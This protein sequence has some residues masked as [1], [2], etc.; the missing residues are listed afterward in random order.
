MNCDQFTANLGLYLDGESS[1]AD[2]AA[3]ESHVAECPDCQ[4]AVEAARRDD[5]E[6]RRAF[7]ERRSAS[8]NLAERVIELVRREPF[9]IVLPPSARHHWM[10]PGIAQLLLAAAAGFFLAV[11]I[12][13]P[14]QN[15]REAPVRV[16]GQPVAQVALATGPVEI[17]P[18]NQATWDACEPQMPLAAGTCVRT[19]PN[20][21]CEL[22]TSDGNSVCLAGETEVRLA[23]S[24][25]VEVS[26]GRLYSCNSAGSKPLEIKSPHGT[27]VAPPATLL[28]FTC[29]PVQPASHAY[30][31]VVEGE[32]TVP[33]AKEAIKAGKKVKLV[34]G[35]IADG[36]A[37][38]PWLDTAWINSLLAIQSPDQ[39]QL[40]QRVNHL[41]AQV[42]ATKLSH[43]YEDEL[44]RLGDAGTPPLVQYLKSTYD[45]PDQPQR[46]TAA[47]IIAEVGQ[48]QRIPDLIELLADSNPRV[49][50]HAAKGL[51]RLTG[52]DQ[53]ITAEQWE[54][55]PWASCEPAHVKWQKWWSKNCE[56]Y[57][58]GRKQVRATPSKPF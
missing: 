34:D 46:E 26:C 54:A 10:A 25:T 57:P 11:A 44:R 49:R 41:L 20:V 53:G 58:S 9:P 16:V 15:G 3:L 56:H 37:I 40:A 2:L 24:G 14:W 43:L 45:Q 55:G 19:G 18:A 17:R 27:V 33:A 52:H 5:L 32:A 7:E 51:R 35:Q 30:I 8:A 21:Q 36:Q 39:P 1:G 22:T 6:L 12:F 38:D 29:P 4:A 31:T 48:P 50:F 13:R 42:G 28:S 47:K 23:A